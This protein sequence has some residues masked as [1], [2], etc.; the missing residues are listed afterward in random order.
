M[1]CFDPIRLGTDLVQWTPVVH[2]SGQVHMFVQ[3]P[4]VLPAHPSESGGYPVADL[5][6]GHAPEGMSGFRRRCGSLIDGC[7]SVGH[8]DLF[9]SHF[10]M[11]RDLVTRQCKCLRPLSAFSTLLA[12]D[13]KKILS[14]IT[15]PHVLIL[16]IH[17]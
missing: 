11:G 13:C 5:A 6:Q 9:L 7:S 15:R 16:S 12:H 14:S 3:S 4:P 8:F 1:P 17:Y 2:L 10:H